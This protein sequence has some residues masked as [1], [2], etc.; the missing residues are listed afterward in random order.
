[1]AGNILMEQ[2]INAYY[3]V[4]ASPKF[5]EKKWVREKARH[6]EAQVL[7]HADREDRHT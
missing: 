2:A 6:D 1:M 7:Y 3:T 4:T 5:P